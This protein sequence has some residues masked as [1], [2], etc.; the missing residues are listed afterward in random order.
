MKSFE[1]GSQGD[2][3]R[4]IFVTRQ[5]ACLITRHDVLANVESLIILISFVTKHSRLKTNLMS[6]LELTSMSQINYSYCPW[7][8][9]L[10][11]FFRFFFLQIL[12]T[13][14]QFSHN[15]NLFIFF[16]RNCLI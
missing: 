2:L 7:A 1:T 15:I 16:G 3:K 13:V 9:L 5:R 11:L 8:N 14:Y 4:K 6:L 12:L 10:L